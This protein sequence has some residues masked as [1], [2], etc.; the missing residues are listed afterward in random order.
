[1]NLVTAEE[2]EQLLAD[3]PFEQAVV[4]PDFSIDHHWVRTLSNKGIPLISELELG[5]RYFSGKT[6]AL[7][8]SNGKSTAVKWICDILR[9]QG[10]QAH[11]AGNYGIPISQR[12]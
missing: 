8:G 2:F 11:I 1:M 4:S 5:W 9:A 10:F 3:T 12:L 7:T 6:I